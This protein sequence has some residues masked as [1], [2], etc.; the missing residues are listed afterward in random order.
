[1]RG[2]FPNPDRLLLPGQYVRGRLETAMQAQAV[3]VP[4]RA[5]AR[6]ANGQASVLL[7]NA[8]NQVERQEIQTGATAGDRWV[9]SSGL[10]GGERVIVEGLQKVRPG[11]TVKPVPFGFVNTNAPAVA[12]SATH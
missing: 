8:Q 4:Q 5:V 11:A 2:E 9:V 7:V 12:A 6:D 3:T 10:V 1:L